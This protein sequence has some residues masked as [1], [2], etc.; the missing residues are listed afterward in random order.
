MRQ[1]QHSGDSEVDASSECEE[2]ESM[3]GSG[4]WMCGFSGSECDELLMQGVKPW[5]DVAEAVMAALSG[6]Y[7]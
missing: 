2:E 5:D 3:Y 6:D 4:E 1:M 7:Y